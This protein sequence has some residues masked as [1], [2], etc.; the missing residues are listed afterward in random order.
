MQ[1]SGRLEIRCASG[2]LTVLPF[3]LLLRGPRAWAVPRAT[4]AHVSCAEDGRGGFDVT[5]RL[6]DGRRFVLKGFTA[7]ELPRLRA[8][9]DEIEG[10]PTP[11]GDA[12][13]YADV[14]PDSSPPESSPADLPPAEYEPDRP[15][16]APTTA[17]R[18][19]RPAGIMVVESL[20]TT[21]LTVPD[22]VAP[23][24]N[25]PH[26]SQ[27]APAPRPQ[28]SAAG[29]NT[30]PAAERAHM[31]RDLPTRTPPTWTPPNGR[32]WLPRVTLPPLPTAAF[33]ESPVEPPTPVEGVIES[34]ARVES[35][36]PPPRPAPVPPR[37]D[38]VTARRPATTYSADSLRAQASSQSASGA[39]AERRSRAFWP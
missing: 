7:A 28:V 26:G 32:I 24:P 38:R 23:L 33:V 16:M 15:E 31:P 14:A 12:P 5:L 4:V 27:S 18:S 29:A 10:L 3:R 37:A 35:P 6:A 11:P 30:L 17:R 25:G 36:A 9:F 1:E 8:A 20:P 22:T 2:T 19:G 39:K 21:P 34:N 13:S